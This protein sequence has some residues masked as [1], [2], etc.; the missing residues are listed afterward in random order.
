MNHPSHLLSSGTLLVAT[1]AHTDPIYKRAVILLCEHSVA[2]GSFGLMINKSIS[3]ELPEENNQL[4]DLSHPK[5]TTLC[6]GKMQP[7][8]MMIL[9][10]SL[11][12]PIQTLKVIDQVYLGGDIQFLQDCLDDES[13]KKIYL[14]FGYIGWLATE[15]EKEIMQGKWIA[16]PGTKELIFDTPRDL[17]W[18]TVLEKMGGK[19][20]SMA[21]IPDDLSLN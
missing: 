17:L 14:C 20:S 13:C 8:Q 5:I 12:H 16:Y 2:A 18:Q 10:T 7:G 19:Y 6:G 11:N 15:L 4:P 3:V 21:S 9:H 1:P